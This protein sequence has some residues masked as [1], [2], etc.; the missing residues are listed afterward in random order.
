MKPFV[1]LFLL[2]AIS[3]SLAAG[4][5]MEEGTGTPTEA[6]MSPTITMGMEP[7]TAE[8]VPM[9]PTA[10]EAVTGTT[11]MEPTGT[12]SEAIPDDPLG[13]VEIAPGD[14]IVIGYALVTSGPN[15]NLGI[16]SL[17]G[18]EIALDDLGN[19]LLG[20]EIQLEGED[21]GCST[22]GGQ[23]AASRLITNRQIVGIVGPTCSSAG[24]VLA[25]VIDEAGMVTISPSNTA[26]GLTDP[27][28]H[29]EGFL[30]T[31]HN[32]KVQGALAAEFVY[33]ELGLTSAATIHDGSIYADQLVSV[34]AERFEEL[35]GTVVAQ[36][37][38]NTTD[39]DMRPVL[40]R[41]ALEQPQIIYYPVFMPTGGFIT[42][43]AREVEGLG[44]VVLMGADGLF[45][46]DFIEAAGDS[47]I[48]MYLSN[49]DLTLL[50]AAYQE[51]LKKHE[52]KYN[53]PPL[54]TYH[55]NA[56]DATMLIAHAVEDVAVEAEDGTLYIPRQALRDALYATRNYQGLT[57]NLTC[58]ENGDCADPYI[59]VFEITSSDLETWSPGSTAPDANP[60]K[61]Y[62]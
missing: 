1:R 3:L 60:K 25:P 46:P 47:A 48:G 40:T 49:P 62:P 28:T 51:F 57:G 36:E 32:D 10:T 21:S 5:G 59:A 33:H 54:S 8:M 35:G 45:N 12:P 34:F 37:S 50:G 30:R 2:L 52:E 6:P 13:V 42:R 17:R 9:G 16:D 58:D 38:V 11:T 19:T 24:N 23:A 15:S 31:A 29:V 43:Q 20:H 53:E 22:E 41:M 61:I 56:Y 4:C 44:E 55:A 26:P 7:A 18:V 39:T 27:A 14:P